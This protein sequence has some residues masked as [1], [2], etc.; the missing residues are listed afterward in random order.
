MRQLT[1]AAII[2]RLERGSGCNKGIKKWLLSGQGWVTPLSGDFQYF[3]LSLGSQTVPALIAWRSCLG[4]GGWTA[5]VLHKQ[6]SSAWVT[7]LGG[8]RIT[9][10]L[11]WQLPTKPHAWLLRGCC[12]A[13]SRTEQNEQLGL[14]TPFSFALL[15]LCC[16]GNHCAAN[17]HQGARREQCWR[18]AGWSVVDPPQGG[19]YTEV[20]PISTENVFADNQVNWQDKNNV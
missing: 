13:K 16:S 20:S 9:W 2:V 17:L 12:S 3:M 4:E 15:D 10:Y 11:Q 19:V 14:Q 1:G 6:C 5:T 18:R 7:L 8:C